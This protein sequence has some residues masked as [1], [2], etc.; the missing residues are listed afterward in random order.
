[1]LNLKLSTFTTDPSSDILALRSFGIEDTLSQGQVL[2]VVVYNNVVC[3]KTGYATMGRV[4]KLSLGCMTDVVHG[5]DSGWWSPTY[6]PYVI[7]WYS[8]CMLT[9]FLLQAIVA[10]IEPIARQVL[11]QPPGHAVCGAH[12]VDDVLGRI[13]I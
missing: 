7:T 4:K 11:D 8:C 9:D 13:N 6:P 10:L 3:H 2:D 12:P 1:M 5:G